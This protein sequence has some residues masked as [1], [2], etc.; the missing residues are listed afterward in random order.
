M[1]EKILSRTIALYP[2]SDVP[3]SLG[4]RLIGN[5]NVEN[6]KVKSDKRIECQ[7][8]HDLKDD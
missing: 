3:A 2:F 6:C 5:I 8:K 4:L 1:S 7:A